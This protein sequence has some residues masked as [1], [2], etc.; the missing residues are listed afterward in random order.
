MDK[1]ALRQESASVASKL[2]RPDG[3]VAELHRL[4]EA[5]ADEENLASRC[6]IIP[7]AGTTFC[8]PVLIRGNPW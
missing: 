6:L 8:S 2:S 4:L 7:D 1:D 5:Y 3:L